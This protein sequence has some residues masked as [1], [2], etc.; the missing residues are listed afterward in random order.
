M[1]QAKYFIF[2]PIFSL[3]TPFT[4]TMVLSWLGLG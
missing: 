3:K 4:K 2:A 1:G